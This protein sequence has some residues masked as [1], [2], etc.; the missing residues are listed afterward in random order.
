MPAATTMPNMATMAPPST[1]LGIII[2]SAANLGIRPSSIRIAPAATTTLIVLD[3][4][5]C[6]KP[7]FCEKVVYGKEFNSPPITTAKPSAR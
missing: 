1:G 7:T 5:N 4:D 2:A 6:T 3:L